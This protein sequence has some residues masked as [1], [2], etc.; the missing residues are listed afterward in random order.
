M[1]VHPQFDPIAVQVGPLAVHWYGLMYLIGFTLFYLLGL[2]RC[3]QEWRGI[4]K[5]NLEDLLFVGMVGVI[6]GGR[7]GFVLLYQPEY[8]LSHPLEIFSVWQGGMSAHGGFIGVILALFYFAW[9]NKKSIL[10]VGD[11]VAP[12][13]PLGFF[14]GRLGNFINGELWG[15][16]ASADLPWSMIFPQAGD[17]VPRHPSQLYEATLEGLVLFL[18]VWIYSIKKRP[19]GA[20]SGLFLFGYG[21]ARFVV[22]F[23]REPDSYLGLQAL[24]LSRGQWLSLPMIIIGA[25]L[26]I[27]ACPSERLETEV[28]H[29]DVIFT[30]AAAS[31]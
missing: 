16:V 25:G 20:V 13:V 8:Y 23:F 14:F 27:W 11:F 30:K 15:R 21:L 4:T 18:V 5:A 9:R 24:N 19:P 31:C 12:L 2:Y 6:V 26:W 1:L 28:V 7:L 10:T 17:G 29:E 3:R 22:E